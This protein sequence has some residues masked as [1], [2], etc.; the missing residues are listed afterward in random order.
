LPL[1]K[2]GQPN[3][4]FYNTD[5][6]RGASWNLTQLW[7]LSYPNRYK[8]YV[9][10]QLEVYK[11]R[12]WF[13][14]GISNGQFTSGVGTNCV[15]LAIADSYNS[16]IRDYDVEL[17]YKAIRE[18]ELKG[19]GRPAGSGKLDVVA[20]MKNGYVPFLEQDITDTTGSHFSA[21][22]TLEYS[23]SAFAAAQMAKS[24]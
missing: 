22:H 21:S 11:N 12:G 7:A 17:A 20:F 15:V 6:I 5:A 23:Y 24:L 10:T 8:D 19:T 9:Q 14:D 13:G 1:N 16:G 2:A 4:N 3:Y 18:N